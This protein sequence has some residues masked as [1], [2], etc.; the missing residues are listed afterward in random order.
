MCALSRVSHVQ[1]FEALWTIACQ[2]PPSMGFSSQEYWSG[3]PSPSSGDRPNPG[4]E[5]TSLMSPALEGRFFTTSTQDEAILIDGK[6]EF[7]FWKRLL[8]IQC[9]KRA[10]SIGWENKNRVRIQVRRVM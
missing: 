10:E 6:I 2:A 1:P 7:I 3:L 5:P 9:I 4:I 8:W